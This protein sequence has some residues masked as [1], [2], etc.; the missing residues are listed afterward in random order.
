METFIPKNKMKIRLP[1]SS[2]Q[3]V[4]PS[5]VSNFPGSYKMAQ[6]RLLPTAVPLPR[7]TPV[8][9]MNGMLSPNLSWWSLKQRR[10]M[11]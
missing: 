5:P 4:T 10:G 9:K 3:G 7:A 6:Y 11:R 1:N 2:K 8:W